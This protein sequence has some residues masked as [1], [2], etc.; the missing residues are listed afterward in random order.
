MLQGMER[1]TSMELTVV[2][3]SAACILAMVVTTAVANDALAQT[4]S[5]GP[6]SEPRPR[7]SVV[8]LAALVGA[9][10]WRSGEKYDSW[11][12]ED[13]PGPTYEVVSI[14]GGGRVGFGNS[15]DEHTTLGGMLQ[16]D[17]STSAGIF[18]S[19]RHGVI[20]VRV[21]PWLEVSER[22]HEGW[23]GRLQLLLGTPVG[24]EEIT[25]GAGVGGGLGYSWRRRNGRQLACG[26]QVD[27]T[28]FMADEDGD[29][30]SYSYFARSISPAFFVSLRF[31]KP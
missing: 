21:G 3:R 27:Y 29:H 22:G 23:F 20:A 9:Y 10:F 11:E 25:L 26:L 17:M 30:G 16:M 7:S 14:G 12:N 6:S 1:P 31:P 19:R 4:A 18:S 28:R 2:G 24:I 8:E 15:F 13:S 5:A